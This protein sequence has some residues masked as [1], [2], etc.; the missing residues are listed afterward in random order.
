METVLES[1]ISTGYAVC[2]NQSGIEHKEF[3]HGIRPDHVF[4]Q[5]RSGT[6]H[7]IGLLPDLEKW[8]GWRTVWIPECKCSY[9]LYC[10]RGDF[11]FPDD[12]HE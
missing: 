4:D 11:T 1:N 9:I 12:S 7:R 5:G 10:D 2:N 6:E 8:Y 3:S